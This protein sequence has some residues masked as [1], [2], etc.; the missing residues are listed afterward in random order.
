MLARSAATSSCARRGAAAAF[1]VSAAL[2]AQGAVSGAESSGLP[3]SDAASTAAASDI[4]VLTVTFEG[5]TPPGIAYAVREGSELLMDVD[6]LARLGIAYDPSTARQVDGRV[7]APLGAVAGLRWSLIEKEQR[8]VLSF[9]PTSRPLSNIPFGYSTAPRPLTPD[10]GGYVNYGVYS[11]PAIE[12]TRIEGA[13][14]T[15]GGSI[16][17]SI[18]GPYGIGATSVLINAK[19]TADVTGSQTVFLDTNW[20]WDDLGKLRTLQVGDAIAA[21]GWWGQA[22]RFGGVQFS[23]NYTLQPGFITYPLLAVGGLATAPSTTEVLVNDIRI[24][25]QNVPAGPFSITNIPT[26]TGAGDLNLVVRDAFGQERVISQPFYVAQQL[27]RP[28]LTEFSI[29]AGAE[30]LNYGIR[31]FD[32][33]QGYASAYARTGLTQNLTAEARAEFDQDGATA[34]LGGDLLVGRVGVVSVGAAFSRVNGASGARYLLGFDRQGR[35]LSFGA[36]ATRATSGYAEIGQP[37]PRVSSSSTAFFRA[38]LGDLG[39]L[40]L[41]YTGQRYF[42]AQPV[43]VYTASFSRGFVGRAYLTLSLSRYTS[44][45]TQTQ[46][47]AL[48][49]VPIDP[50]TSAT[51]SVQSTKSGE[52]VEHRGEALL[53]RS[54][55]IGQGFGYYMRANTDRLLAGGVSYAGPYGQYT[56]EAS[57]ADG[58]TALRASATGA[59]AWVGRHFIASQSIEQGFAVVRVG[60]LGDVRVLQENQ[61]VGRTRGGTLALTQIPALSPIKIAVDPVSVPME[62]S[63]EEVARE[64]VLLPRTGVLVDFK[65]MRDRTALVRLVLPSGQPVPVGATVT[66]DGRAEA[67]PVGFDGEAF[68]TRVTERQAITVRFNG[69][70]C[71]V[72]LPL[73]AESAHSNTGPLACDPRPAGGA[74]R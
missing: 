33:G 1:A 12:G 20:R 7:L 59:V 32:Y 56:L 65:A 53:Q 28:G 57:D 4:A 15:L 73:D 47:L 66:I 29:S 55:P 11:T 49:T 38:P 67:F 24:G 63:L 39:A 40:S 22:V 41:G 62:I 3:S 52:D 34:G 64:V 6:T 25:N 45:I 72:V 14:S 5:R 70:E 19:T 26:I 31:N 13:G 43:S 61:E 21:P 18:F 16:G 23:S 44:S 58:A 35:L 36:R 51:A 9:E 2:S 60:D 68:L 27:L 74:A 50:L 10:W 42:T 71:R 48:V 17:A 8:L 37:L 30:R 54:L 46:A 69:S